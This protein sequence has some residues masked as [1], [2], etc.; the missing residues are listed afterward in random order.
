M[1]FQKLHEQGVKTPVTL[2]ELILQRCKLEHGV[3]PCLASFT[4]EHCYQTFFTC[5]DKGNFDPEDIAVRFM[6]HDGPDIMGLDAFKQIDSVTT[7]PAR[8]E[9]SGGL[10][11]IGSVTVT[12]NEFI[13]ACDILDPYGGTRQGEWK[14]HFFQVLKARNEGSLK[15][16]T[17]ILKEGFLSPDK[18]FDEDT[19]RRRWYN[20]E[21]LDFVGDQAIFKIKDI[22]K[23]LDRYRL[24]AKTA[25][26]LLLPM[27]LVTLS[28][29]VEPGNGQEL[30]RQFGEP[31]PSNPYYFRIDKEFVR[32]ESRVLDV[33]T[34][35]ARGAVGDVGSGSATAVEHKEGRK[36]QTVYHEENRRIDL[37]I[38]RILNL[39]GIP[40][41]LI[42]LAGMTAEVDTWLTNDTRTFYLSKNQT[43]ATLIQELLDV[44][45]AF[46][47]WDAEAQLILFR[48]VRPIAPDDEFID[49]IDP[50]GALPIGFDPIEQVDDFSDQLTRAVVFFGLTDWAVDFRNP[51]TA[52]EFYFTAEGY[53][54]VDAESPFA[55]NEEI[56]D[57]FLAWSI[58][59]DRSIDVLAFVY[60]RV[61]RNINPLKVLRFRLEAREAYEINVGDFTLFEHPDIQDVAGNPLPL[62]AFFTGKSRNS[63]GGV[64]YEMVART[65]GISGD[66]RWA[67]YTHPGV[68]ATEGPPPDFDVADEATKAVNAYYCDNLTGRM[69]DGS[70]GYKYL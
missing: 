13:D 30:V 11:G 54:D 39:A 3:A 68:P 51:D 47:F 7:I 57:T 38:K 55:L 48:V 15:N 22:I 26:K 29:T 17:M 64:V 66:S 10:G 33:F 5:Q 9:T 36:V 43:A 45:S 56:E 20:L 4:R 42:D 59:R 37:V 23:R 27:D 35:T 41:S 63:A 25:A 61:S 52:D 1:S 24:P 16:S 58:P 62:Q 53:A 44:A 14:G 65:T 6:M 19:S 2:I 12:A 60:R 21:S 40:D 28:M 67:F 8:I 34:L 69:P 46:V 50:E 70:P 32:S 18:T 31:S 49:L